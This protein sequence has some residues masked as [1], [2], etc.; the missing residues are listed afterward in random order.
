MYEDSGDGHNN[1]M[2]ISKEEVAA[3]RLR[4]AGTT[5]RLSEARASSPP[6]TPA[7]RCLLQ[8]MR[9]HAET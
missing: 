5:C 8:A 2:M 9:R 7:R 4:R 6:A 3:R 1:V